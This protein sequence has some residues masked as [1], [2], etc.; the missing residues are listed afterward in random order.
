MGKDLFNDRISRFSIRKLNVGVCSVLLGTLVMVGTASQ[1]SADETANQV[2]AG[3][4]TSTTATVSDESSSQTA[5]AAQASTEV[6]NILSSTE[7]N[8]QSQT[9]SKVSEANSETSTTQASSETTS[10]AASS[11]SATTAASTTSVAGSTS[12]GNTTGVSTTASVTPASSETPASETASEAQGV[13]VQAE[14]STTNALSS[15][16]EASAV[17]QPVV[18]AETSGRR[19]TRRAIGDPN[20]ESLIGDDVED[21]T[22]TPKVEKPGFT[23]NVDAKSM[24]SQISWLDFGDVANWTGTTTVL[25]PK[26]EVKPTENLEEKLALQVGSTYTKE[27][28]PGYVVTVKVK[29]LK[30]FQA[31]EIYKKRMENQGATEAEKATYD[32]NAKNGYVSGVTS[33]AAKQAFNNGEEAK[34]V[35]D[36]QNNWTEIRFE[37]IDTKTKK[38]TISSALNGGNIG[39]QFEISAT[40]R[41]KTVKPAIVM[42][43]G[44][45]A[46]PGELVMFT[47]NGEGWQHIGEWKKFTRPTTSVT[48]SPQDTENLFGPNPKFNNTNLNQLRRSTQVG[49]EKKPVAW[50]YFGN[51]DKV[52]GGLG[53]G[54]FGPN[55]SEGNYTVPIVMTRGASEV[56]LYVA[57]GGK[58]SA[59]L[60]FFPIDEGDAPESYGKA[61]H[62][63]ATVDGITGAKVN[64]P[65]IGNVSPDMDENTVLDW[66]GDD[67]A[68]TADEGIDQLLPDELKGTTNE[69]IKMDRTRPG[70]YKLS[71][72]AH[73]DGA[74]EA[75][76]YG[77]ID[78]NQNGTFDEDE[79]SDLAR[80][81]NDGTVELTFANSKTYIDPSVKELGARVR[82]AKKANEIESPTGM[83]LSGEV[84]D[85]RTQITHP[86]KGEFK[87]TSGPQ[88]AKQT[89]TV[90]FTARGE[91]KYELNS[92]AV[93][94]ETV[95]PYIVDKDG[96]RAT[97]DGDGYYVVPGQGKYKIT[98]NGKDVDVEF[99]PEDNF[100]GT[101]DGI[102]I[103][104]SDNNGYDTGWSTKFPDQ[105]PNIN[106]QLNTMDGQYVPTVTPIEIEGVDKTST[107]VQGATQ[108]ETPTFN[109][110]ET[111]SNGD[112]IAI[113][114]SAEYPAKLVDPATGLTT[115]APSVTVEGEGTYTINPSTGEVTFTPDPSFTGTAKGVEVTLSAP[116]GR[117]KDGKIQQDYI[118]TATAKYTP[119]VTPITVTP[120]DKV[121]ADV[122]NVPQTQTPT[123]DLSNDKTAEIT[124]KK[125][126]DP[127][128]GQPTDETTVTVAG[129]GSYTID[130][131]TG[132]VTF[133]PEKDF[134]GTAKGVTVQATATITNA[135][136]KTATITSD[137]TYTPTVV[138]AVPTAQPATSKDVQGATQTGTPTFAGT[139]VQVNG[140][141]KAI[142]IK[143][144]SYTLLDNDG[145]EVTSTP[146]YAA[147]GTTEI[148][149]YSIDSATSQVTFTP[150]DK[151]YTGVVTPAKVQAESSNGIKVDTTYTPEIVPVTP[152]ATPAETEDIQ[153][154]TQ[155]GK[156]EFKGGTVTVD[157]VEKTVAI[158]E[159]VPATFDDGSTT[160]TVDGVGTYTVASDGTVTFVPEKSFTGKAPAVTVVREDKNGT[161]ASAT[162]T[163]TV[164]PVTPTATPAESTGPQGLVQTGTVTFTEGDEV[165]PIDK[166]TITLLDE[167]GQPATSVVAKSPEGKEIG[168]FT[169]DKDT[170]VVTFT[171]TDKSYSGDVVPVKVQ[172]A[173]TN[174]TTVET[175]YTPKITPVVPTSEDATSTD[176]QGQTQTG[177][178]TFTEGN[179]NVPIDEDTPATFE[180][181]ST[182]KTV[183]GEGTYTVSPDGTVTF[184]P[185][186]SFTGTASG[187]TVKRVDKNGTEITAKYTPTVTPV[188]PTAAPA[189]STDIQ[190]ATQ[191]G[192][193]EF[194]EGDSRVPMNDAVPATFDDGS[195][196]KTVDGV[197]TYTVAADGTVTFVPEK[198]FVGTAPAVTV[199]REDKNGTKASATYT[200]TVTP[201]TPTATPAETT[202][203]QGATQSG[204]PTFTEGNNRVPMNDDVPATFDDGSTSKTVDGV[205]TY[206]VAADGTVTFVPEPSFTGT[207]P[208]VTV[209]REDKN[210]TK[211][212]ATY[213]PTV[214]PVTL[215]PTNKVSEDIQNIPQTETPTFA[216][217][218]DETAQITS[219]KLIDPATG[220]PT[221]ETTVTVAG[222]G[223]YT[224]DP[225]TGAVTFTPEKDFVGT[226]TGV[227]I[228]AIATITNED[229]KT[230]TITSDAS[231]T[232]TVVA[233][234]PTAKPATSKDI[235]GATQTGTPTFEGATVQV[236]GQDKA[237]TIKD[238][239]Y[240]LLDKDGNEVATTP[241]Y[242]EDGTTEIGTYSIDPATGQVTFTPTDKSYTGK[243]TPVKVQAESS[244]GIKVDTTYTPEIVPVTPTAT[245]AETTDIQ[246]ATQTGKPEFKGGTVTVDGVEKT[247][248]INE[249]IP[250]TFDDGSTT[251]T[252]DGVGTYTVAA[253]GTVTFVPEKSFTGTAPAV[254]VVR[255]DKNGTKA[256][257]TYTPT[258]T[259]VTP[260]ATP[261]ETTDIQ[262]ATQTGKP[263]FTEGDSRVPMNDDVPATFDDGSTTKT[264]DG[265]GTYTVAADG[266]V[267]F[268]P[269][270]SF[271]GEA[272]A[273][274]VVREDKNGTK[275]SATYTP[276]V[277][278]VTPTATPVETTGKQGQTQTGKPVFTE[279]DSR[280]PMNDDV[281]A[282][283]DDGSTTKTVEGV[284]TYTVAADGTVTFVPEKSF[285]GK[286]PA[287][288][289][290]RE[291]K[292]GTKASAAYTPTVT[293]VTPT[294][295][296]AESTGP[297]GLVQTGTVTFTE[298]DPVAPIDKDTITLLDE[299]GQP[300]ASV[301][302]KSPAGD[303][304]GTFTVDKETGVV[305]FTPTDKSYSGDVVPVKVQAADA[306]GTTVETTY[307]PKIT[308]VVP[309]SE[310]ATSTDIQGATQTG[311]PTFTEGNPNV[312][313]DEDTPATFEDG[314]TTKTVDGEGTYTVSP[315][316]TVT[317]VPEKSFTGT[318]S[319]VTVK[320]VDKNGTE[321]TAKYTPTVTP[322]TPTAEPATST[323]IQGATQ[324]GK[325]VFTEGDSRVPMNDDVPATFDDGST[326]KTV[327]GVGTYTVAADGTVTFVPE[328]SFTGEAPAVTVVR[329]D[330]NGTKA[331]ATY[332]P[333]VT[334]V[335]PTAEDTTSNDKQGQTQTGTPSFTPGNPNVPM[336]DDTPATF[337]DGST[338]KTIPGEGTYTVAPDGTVT[339]VPEKSFTGE[340][341]GVTVKRVDK[342]GTPVTA[343]YT[344][345]VTPVTP[346]ATP[347]ES[348]APQ[349][350]VQ[351]GTVTFTE[352]DPVAPIDKDTI[353][354]L[355]ENGQPAASVDAKSPAGDVIGTFTVDKETGVVTFTPTDKSYSGDVV[356]VK[357]QG[358]DTNGTVAETTYTPKITPVVPT[359]D[360]ATSTDIQGQ[361][362]TGT[363]SFTPGNP[364]IPMDDDTPATFDDGST[365]K[366]IPGEGTYTVAPNGTVTFVPEKSFTGEG[367][368]V[369]VKRVDKNGT[370]ITAKYTPT[371]TPVTPTAEPTTSTGK[372][373]QTQTGKP[374]FTEGDSRV[375]MNDDVPA[376]F[377]DGTTTKTVDGVGK[378]TVAADGT[379]TFVPEK[380]FVG[381]APAVTVVREDVNGTKASATYT[382][383]VTSVTPTATP[384]E[385]TGPQGVVQT[386]TV[387]FTEG[388]SVAP[389]DKDTITLLDE[390]GQPAAAVFAKSPAGNIIGTFTVD[391]DTGVVTFTPTD[392]SYSGDVV[393]VK[394]QAAD[395]NGT[396][397]ETTYTPKIT[398]V[399][400]TSEDATSTD[401]QGATQ[402]GKPSF[403]EGNPNVPIDEDTPATFEDG[404]TTKTVD[405]E[406]TYTVSPDGTVT[407][408][409]EKSFTGT[410]SGVTVKR[411]DKNGTE[412][413]AKYTPTVTPVTPTATPAEST[414]IQGATQTGKPEF[415]EGDSRVPMNDDVPATFDD[416]STTKTV[417]GVGTYT[418]AADG[419]VTFVPEKSFVG[420]APAVTV[421]REDMNGT[422][423]SAT[424]TP[425]VTP[426]TPTAAPTTSTDIQGATQTGKPKFTEG[427]SR[428][429][430]NDDVPATFDDGSTTK[431][432]EGVGTYT[433][434]ADG[435]VTFVPEKSFVGTAPAVTVVREDVN[436]TK[437]SATY[438][439]TVTPVTPTGEPATSTD[440]QGQ[441]QT[442]K[443]SFTPGNPSVPM[444][445]D[446]PATFEDG[447]TTK[448]IP[449]EGTYTVASDGTV[450]F[451][452]EKAFTGTGTGVTVKR[453]DKNGTAIT[454]TYT[455]TVTPVTPTAE[456]VTS[457]GNKGQTQTGKP[458]FTEGD[459]RVPMNNQVPATFDDGSTT[460]TI[461]GVGTYTVA[462]DGTVTFTPEPEFTGTA[463][464]VTVVREDVNGTKASATYTPTVL[465]ITKFVDK[466]GKE[467]P[468]YPTVDG[469]QPKADIPGYRFVE[470]KKLPNGDIEHVYEQVTTSYVDEN[471]KPIPGYP[472][473]DGQQPKK[474]I[475]GYEFVKT[476]VDENGNTQHIYKQIVTPTPVPDTTPTPEPQPAPQ[477]EEPKAPVLPETKEE[478]H[479]INP[480]DK[481][482]Q[483]PETGSEDSNLAIFGLASLL[484][485]FGLYGTKRRKR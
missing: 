88:G 55:I 185:E 273:V 70:N 42:A 176:I 1:V 249:D 469:E 312:P 393:P 346:T 63:I 276:T 16:A 22:S 102:S 292:N 62:T 451:V 183:D 322:V 30:P 260:T 449:G 460:K 230:S 253:D 331:S 484:A 213:T 412:I 350:V 217:S 8:S 101:A 248:E 129:E 222:E 98:A 329:E 198:S 319:G 453:V 267:T 228:Q 342:N 5:V 474:D 99:I 59:M 314:S 465:P 439:P 362:Q 140:E 297:Q 32:P 227:K 224:I 423:A 345:T 425:T 473:E 438:T 266:T 269:E 352:G 416:G 262:G 332:T 112:K 195:T 377:E 247:V 158:N 436:G 199:V 311:K 434:A 272:P 313:I 368:G 414:D 413:T 388:D 459:S 371:V 366:T 442:G 318:A 421:V 125:L 37:N 211:A 169:V 287:V 382:P 159:A 280:V 480:T 61:M 357:V 162:Y 126:V 392:K 182:T 73:T 152:T 409:P 160:K 21:A 426:V 402:T 233:A 475:P 428:V 186:K 194:T 123:F 335:T 53:T 295:T 82:I 337:E 135:N 255:E 216:L 285:T 356:P 293:P 290:V 304:I 243:V 394:V 157:G 334:P 52:T 121:S 363:P 349:G 354:L 36:A 90:T 279:G 201:V 223:T 7:T 405:G 190:G 452:P 364:A 246:G 275:A 291:D 138:A 68:T 103:R 398:P 93:I 370:E 254:T 192:K 277:T 40:F 373:G 170:G 74:S 18:T 427:D 478:A 379:V 174:G 450:T 419:T 336:D 173:D 77:W 41:G 128:T 424:Y 396:T 374:E 286:A 415:T 181:G 281:P 457:I 60:G 14:A 257:A 57:S 258:V 203:V 252:V 384:A 64:Q 122:Q 124:S 132:A 20:D 225:T 347:A 29:S 404:S 3:D 418:V 51:P 104:R 296:P 430:M 241:A 44:E 309:T 403:T 115:D 391:K 401:I 471:G 437:A 210:G 395:T 440:I 468:G 327:D 208:A 431:T 351:T 344:P 144:N 69:M 110:T 353:T 45:S 454:A 483:L 168:T 43:D 456:S 448:V 100:L 212:S 187:V 375:P 324:T 11:T 75:Y 4:V 197:G 184:V 2:Q 316:G 444:D 171:P 237:I 136:G 119:T 83:A 380:S 400:P 215:T 429:P 320:R 410:A 24:A 251:K 19:R 359:A 89:A 234:V 317:F 116:V 326:T 310:D 261:A 432:V 299:N 155:T 472:T 236:N 341:S 365:T 177:K 145:N 163:P 202:G 330:M 219:K 72:E 323:D 188:T 274:T 54:I 289:V 305:T 282:T 411:V 399:A 149:T 9:V 142:T 302:A 264:V 240:T 221:D 180:D 461:S 307:T 294:A 372:Q 91:H 209:V 376:T 86:P 200:P 288:T 66:F 479:F 220:Q 134:V 218:D 229:G 189:E 96:N 206:T 250:A 33:N 389:I 433:V 226:A 133:T 154:A 470:T 56:G 358:K 435:T 161:K 65:Y 127:A 443:P 462:A 139:T 15:G 467:I 301:E 137:A 458:S 315:D 278:P 48:Y 92:S 271:T 167:N 67:K 58:Q 383:T 27:I 204:K 455:P 476:V 387:T 85:F 283:F 464:A 31:T 463:P 113:T 151:S 385:S 76:I 263:V 118:K 325:P 164:T 34:I 369:T 231:Y 39:V 38:T 259:P 386:G 355:D 397:V 17:V 166:D 328:K 242:A 303:V 300:A 447:S 114:P 407:F 232:P 238:N 408:V 308:P 146:A 95:E 130:P 321:I 378:Y 165:A 207:A 361:T 265:V 35:A 306:N 481:T 150:T 256:S 97:L 485:G 10:Q 47:T 333:T 105:E 244:N 111:N 179:P 381:T 26:S 482:A 107:D 117:N 367:T 270:K 46:N 343:K 196:T 80:I 172:A 148:G 245:P 23:T 390:N 340:G 339:F 84:E 268:V 94:D 78:F 131:T 50:K 87:E 106:G 298:G 6:A 420:T 79:R 441:T 348:E 446:V 81:T 49:P 153:G 477:T 71:I 284:G 175:T 191:T 466:E 28:M 422:K 193:P 156:P 205:G 445:D 109:T 406:G 360:P 13:D 178:P 120:T 108:K 143:D 214:N 417:D 141:D 239:S 25:V 12:V 338:T 147:D 235:Q